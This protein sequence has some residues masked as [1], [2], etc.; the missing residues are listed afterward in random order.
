MGNRIDSGGSDSARSR[1]VQAAATVMDNLN[2]HGLVA[3]VLALGLATTVILLALE[4]ILHRGPVSDTEAAVL[5]TVLGAAV[6]AVATY[7]GGARGHS[8][9]N[10]QDDD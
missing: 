2:W 5:S 9:G 8:N 1:L 3:I 4:T 10:G 6:G 7:L